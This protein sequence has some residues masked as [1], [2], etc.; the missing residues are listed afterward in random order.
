MVK[1]IIF[2]DLWF[3][4]GVV[5]G[6]ARLGL[7]ARVAPLWLA[8]LGCLCGAAAVSGQV[9]INEV[10]AANSD[11]LLRREAPGYPRLGVTTPWMLKTYDDSRW[12]EGN[13]PF[14]FGTFP[15]VTL[16]VNTSGAMQNKLTTLYVRKAFVASS[17]LAASTNALHLVARHNDG[18]IAF[19]NG[20]EVARR[21][22]G[23]PGMFAYRDQTAFNTN[24]SNAGAETIVLGVASNLLSTGTN[25]LCVQTHNQAA[26]SANFLSMTD[27]RL[28]GPAPASIVTNSTS[29]RYFAG[30]SEPSGGLVDYGLLAGVAQTAVW[31][32]L[33]FNDS[34]WPES[35]GPFGIESANPPDYI[36]GTNLYAAVFN[37]AYSIYSRTLFQASTAEAASSEPLRV[38]VDYDDGV[39]VYLNGREV[40]RRNV[41]TEGTITP[42]NTPATAGHSANGDG[43]LTGREET[44]TLGPANTLLAG[45][46]NVL[47]I[48]LHNSV[49]TSSDMTALVTLST[50]GAGARILC[51][52]TDVGR[53][54]VGVSEPTS[55]DG[56]DG[57]EGEEG[58]EDVDLDEDTPDSEGDWVELFNAGAEPVNLTG[59]S[60][61]DDA[62]KPR[63]WYFPTGS[64]L[65]AQGYLVVMATGFDV[66]PAQGA[67]YL[68]T[69]FKLSSGGEYLGLVDAAGAVV[70]ELAPQLPAQSYFHTYGRAA[71]GEYRY[72]DTATPGAANT[73]TWFT[74]ISQPPSFS[75]LG[76][77]HAAA[78][79][80]Q[81]TPPDPGATVRYTLDGRE[82][83]ATVGLT[84]TGPLT[85]TAAT[86]LRARCLKA[87]E[88]PSA[89]VTHT[90]LVA[91]SAARRSLPAMCLSADPALGLYGPNSSGGPADGEGI[92]AIK[93]GSYVAFNAAQP[94]D[95]QWVNFGAD[96]GA[97]NMP[98][99]KGR[100][101][102]RPAGFEYYP[103]SGVPL[104]TA[105]GLRVSGSPHAR[106]RYVISQPIGSRFNPTSF[107]DK[108][109]F[110]FFFRNELGES[111]QDYA[112]FPE[113]RIT[114]FE[115]M[116]LRA[117][118]NDLSNPFIRDELMRR[119]YI[120][121]G[122]EGSI[123][124][125]VSIYINGVWKGYYNFCEHLR[126]AFMQQHHASAA[127]W[128]VRQV[129][130]F[131]SGDAIHWNQM[132]SLL[133][134]NSHANAAAYVRM[135]DY[136]DIDNVID[137]LLVNAYAAMWDWPHN[138]WVA[139][140]ERSDAGRWRF[141]MWD[142]EGGFGMGYPK[143]PTSYNSFTTD[144]IKTGT[145]LSSDNNGAA[146]FYSYL[147]VSPEFRLRFADRAQKHLFNNGCLTQ[148]SM[149]AHY[150]RL[151]AAINPIMVE[152]TGSNLDE[153][154]YNTWILDG[155]TRRSNFFT[156]L[157]EQSL[158]PATLAPTFS[159]HGG[160]VAP[161][162]QLT[163]TNPNGAGSVYWTTN[164]V[165]PRAVGGAVAGVPYGGAIT[166]PVSA[167]LKARVLSAGGEW[168]PLAEA[169]F[170]VP[171]EV[172]AFL[173]TGS[174]DWTADA[175]WS[176]AP[177][178]YPSG[179]N[180]AVYLNAPLTAD[181]DINIR[182]PVTVGSIHVQ[183]NDS[184]FRNRIRDRSTGN[185]LRFAATNGPAALTVSGDGPGYVEFEVAAGV[186]L[187]SDLRVGVHNTAG[188]AEY[189]ALRLRADWR[190]PGGLIKE[191]DGV[192]T[193]TGENK[194]YTGPTT[195]SRGVL[196]LTQP[197]APALSPSVSVASGGQLRLTS[198]S[199]DG[200]PR[201]YGFGGPLTLASLGRGGTLP[202]SGQGVAGGLR[203][204][205]ETDN[206]VVSVTGGVVFAGLSGIHVEGSRN[207]LELPGVLSG[208][209]GFVKTG[210]GTLVLSGQSK[211]YFGPVTVSNG[212][213]AVSG[214]IG[215]AVELA[216]SGVLSGSG[217]VGPL[218][219]PG[220]VALDR[221]VLTTPFAQAERYAFAFAKTGSPV[222]GSASASQ[223]GVLR[224]LAFEP[225]AAS[226]VIDAYLDVD[227]LVEGDRLRGGLF[228]EGARGL[229]E[230]LASA[231][232]R[233]F[234]PDVNGTVK[235]AGRTYSAY[236]GGLALAATAMPESADFGE[237]PREGWVLEV[238]V[239][240]EPVSFEAWS[241][242][243]PGVSLA[244]LAP[245]GPL[246]DPLGSGLP[247]L[248]RYA[249][250]IGPGE[251]AS[252][253]LPSFSL[254][255]GVPSY[256]FRF[257][258]GKRDI[259]YRVEASSDLRSWGR[260]LFDSRSDW[261]A[262][263][264]GETLRV[265]DPAAG[266]WLLPWQFYRLRVILD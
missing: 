162:T 199:T 167:L 14:G 126:E 259:T 89:V 254:A 255:G 10:V 214:R 72:S 221:T 144:L 130:E 34:A 168:S 185:T 187:D 75:H 84:Y 127:R 31:A 50:T 230:A 191:G 160:T 164:G 250:G 117:G 236:A 49:L 71:S 32:S 55:G 153:S 124:T 143:R 226:T 82:P 129:S 181:R 42:F 95:K 188:D 6:Q 81:L 216:P 28:A 220:T 62:G 260:V 11:R 244:A 25:V 180:V 4:R 210:G 218:G 219:G 86:V 151:R 94:N 63:K 65:P 70:S 249:F 195:V 121:T 112:F 204:Q 51:R 240:G 85:V 16:G 239:G 103:T 58:G 101:A 150:Q 109:S 228:V 100:S 176:S 262:A 252:G 30:V 54:F 183:Q 225:G 173:Q 148:G 200:Q 116:R 20:V 174:A 26:A 192:A 37:K 61:T 161:N 91:Q 35:A 64:V 43:G 145:A 246:A 184:A 93:G 186:L 166:L 122:Q 179:T 3:W 22:M 17:A 266:P 213:V 5:S 147:R 74:A 98:L 15:G 261:P 131:A 27:L 120:G 258:P 104:R 102:E 169:Q 242:R 99:L 19:L 205:P 234:T 215:A 142:A 76:G 138:N 29:W 33:G 115:D 13:G 9:V 202:P 132:M 238:R 38:V 96:P 140:R 1:T 248:S 237:G 12:S 206:S 201:V 146:L 207:T 44:L 229:S 110:N 21:N 208:A 73:G 182:A 172:P 119:I 106:P 67:D 125:F 79:Q 136:A 245:D 165:D 56:G 128:D 87:G 48:Q 53:F 118:K 196:A 158:W 247:N 235:F 231:T 66:G 134:T 156:Q 57:E 189:G 159:Q 23:N 78:I 193:L 90:Y 80:V 157:T 88:I 217:R 107:L 47:A 256:T 133:R 139:A 257:D 24:W 135:H 113:S 243:A 212:A 170:L 171:V 111:P 68:H 264:D 227:P 223:N 123:G 251:P 175:N 241:A 149:Q 141:Y 41:G 36:L 97:F 18:F 137:Y 105:A 155:S 154:F 211:R 232:V 77:F 233:F 45:G 69:N 2:N 46:D 39:I 265:T 197:A 194:S 222:Y 190:G 152:T 163:I 59:W 224:T 8:A 114:K 203:F 178:P 253:R 177:L 52:P 92:L 209:A 7:K 263:W 83:T 60:L 108:P 40:A 198:A